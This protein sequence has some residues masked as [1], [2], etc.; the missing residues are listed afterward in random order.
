MNLIIVLSL[1]FALFV[2]VLALPATADPAKDVN[3]HMFPEF[4]G[5]ESLDQLVGNGTE[6]DDDADD[7]DDIEARS[8]ASAAA[9][10]CILK[11]LE[12]IMF[13]YSKNLPFSIS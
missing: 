7:D 1:A 3:F 11:V 13:D 4:A 9:S 6:D 10:Q 8:P 2:S 12:K 5:L